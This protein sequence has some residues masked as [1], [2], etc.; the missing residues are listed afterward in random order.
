MGKGVDLWII[1]FIVLSYIES[2][3]YFFLVIRVDK[4]IEFFV[5]FIVNWMWYWGNFLDYEGILMKLCFNI[6]ICFIC[7]KEE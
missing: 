5:V 2:F 4:G 7:D 3:E 6:E 1:F